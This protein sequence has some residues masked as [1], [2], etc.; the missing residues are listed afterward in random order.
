M[1]ATRRLT[2]SSRYVAF[3]CCIVGF[4]VRTAFV[5]HSSYFQTIPSRG[6]PATGPLLEVDN[7]NLPPMTEFHE[8]RSLSKLKPKLNA[9]LM[10]S[11]ESFSACLL[12]MDENFRLYEWLAYHYH[13]LK[14][15]YLVI[16]VD[17]ISLLSPEPVLDLFRN[18]LNMTIISW[19]DSD[20]ADW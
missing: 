8:L 14:L 4:L 10:H 19:T 18:E 13:V 1:M 12:V 16:T 9:S 11:N 7:T 5:S 20:F 17:P 6:D 2:P 3:L 15:R